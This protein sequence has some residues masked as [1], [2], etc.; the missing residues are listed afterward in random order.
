MNPYFVATFLRSRYGQM[1]IDR[2]IT[3]ATGQ[4]HLYK[5]DVR[6]FFLPIIPPLEQNRFETLAREAAAARARAR[7]WLDKAKRAIEIAIE[8]SE[9]VAIE[10][11]KES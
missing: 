6:K 3:G 1:Q 7:A 8:D 11:L 5:R 2:Y 4:L 9:A 10:Y